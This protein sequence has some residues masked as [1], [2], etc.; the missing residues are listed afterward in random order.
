MGLFLFVL[1]VAAIGVYFLLKI[2]RTN[3]VLVCTRCH[4]IGE[5]RMELAGNGLV[6]L[7]LWLLLLVPGIIYSIWRRSS[8]HPVCQSCGSTEL[9]PIDSA[10]GRSISGAQPNH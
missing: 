3:P 2:L 6:E 9:V 8:R 1:L 5:A 7:A 4:E 10:R